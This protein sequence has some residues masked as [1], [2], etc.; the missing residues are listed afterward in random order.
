MAAPKTSLQFEINEH[1]LAWLRDMAV[2]FELPDEHKAL[3]VVLEHAIQDGDLD[4]I[5]TT[6]RCGNC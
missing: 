2:R 3:R 6:I 1:Q 5:F 4:E